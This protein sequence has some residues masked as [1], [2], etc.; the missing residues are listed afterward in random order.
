MVITKDMPVSGI[1]SSWDVTKEVFQKYGIPIDSN[2]A[3]KNHLHGSQ[4][5]SIIS[6]LNRVIGSSEITCIEGG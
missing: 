6:D 5:D 4:L 2:K 1:V 3:I